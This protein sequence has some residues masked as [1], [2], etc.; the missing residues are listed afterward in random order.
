ML[1][2]KNKAGAESR[3]VPR[4]LCIIVC[5]LCACCIGCIGSG[6]CS[7]GTALS[8]TG[9][10]DGANYYVFG[11]YQFK[12]F[13]ME[14]ANLYTLTKVKICNVDVKLLGDF[15][16]SSANFD[17]A[18]RYVETTTGFNADSKTLSLNGNCHN[19]GFLCM[20]FKKVYVENSI[21]YRMELSVLHYSRVFLAIDNGIYQVNVRSEEKFARRL[22]C[23]LPRNICF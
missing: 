10:L 17:F 21:F 4:P 14:I 3:Y 2:V 7:C 11:S 18:N 22:V 20:N 8:G 15:V 1:G 5:L 9:S 13:E 12:T 23:I 19:D 6:C 16:V